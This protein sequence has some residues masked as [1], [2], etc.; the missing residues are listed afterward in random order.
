MSNFPF[1]KIAEFETVVAFLRQNPFFVF[2][3]NPLFRS[4]LTFITKN[5]ITE[6]KIIS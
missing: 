6:N 1:P 5:L 4:K 2:E 3:Y